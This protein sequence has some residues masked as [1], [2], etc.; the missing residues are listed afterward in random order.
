MV[1]A[2]TTQQGN[3]SKYAENVPHSCKKDPTVVDLLPGTPYNQQIANCCK[4]GI[5]SSLL[6]DLSNA[7]S[8]FQL[9]VGEAGTDNK[10]VKVPRNFT[11]KAPGPGYTCGPAKI[12]K[13]TIFITPDGRRMTRALMTWNV[14]CTYI[15]TV[16][17]SE[18]SHLLCFFVIFLQQNYSSLPFMCLFGKWFQREAAKKMEENLKAGAEFLSSGEMLQMV[19]EGMSKNACGNMEVMHGK[20]V[21]DAQLELM[22]DVREVLVQLVLFEEM[23]MLK[24]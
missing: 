10:S 9:T 8:S 12:V 18:N 24:Y 17:G 22:M 16:P 3:C 20:E 15:F 7:A 19:A 1:G 5:L 6:Q 23:Q 14:T 21:A 4:G 13:P 11:L 2:K